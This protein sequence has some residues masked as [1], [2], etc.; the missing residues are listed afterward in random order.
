ML[1]QRWETTDFGHSGAL[2]V[3]LYCCKAVRKV[4]LCLPHY[5]CS[6][7]EMHPDLTGVCSWSARKAQSLL[8]WLKYTA[9]GSTTTKHAL[10]GELLGNTTGV[11][12][13]GRKGWNGWALQGISFGHVC[14]CKCQVWLKLHRTPPRLLRHPYECWRCWHQAVFC[15]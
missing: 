3:E 11:V 9:G 2:P 1:I 6:H 5:P 12:C 4:V 7:L 15:S 10:A 8:C 13:H 14:P